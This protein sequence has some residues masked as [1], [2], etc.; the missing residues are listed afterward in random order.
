[1]GVMA[2][3]VSAQRAAAVNSGIVFH[4]AASANNGV[5]A[6]LTIPAPSGATAGDVLVASL[7]VE[8]SPAISVPVGWTLVRSDINPNAL[9]LVQADYVHVLGTNEPQSYTWNFSAANGASGGIVAYGGV[10]PVKPVDA[11]SGAVTPATATQFTAPSITTSQPGDVLLDVTG[12]GVNRTLMAPAAMTPEYTNATTASGQKTQILAADQV[13]AS[14]GAS[15]S[16]TVTADAAA[17]GIAQLIALRPAAAASPS[18]QVTITAPGNGATVSGTQVVVSASATAAAGIAHVQ[19]LLDNSPLGN[20]LTAPP[21]SVTW[22]T[23]TATNGQHTLTATVV[24]NN[25]TSAT[26]VPVTVN[27]SNTVGGQPTATV[28]LST[29][30][31]DTDATLT[32]SATG[33]SPTNHPVTFQYTWRVNGSVVKVTSFISSTTDSLDLSLPGNGDYGDSISVQVTPQD[34]V[35]QGS[36]V[37]ASATVTKPPT[38]TILEY[39]LPVAGNPGGITVGPDGNFWISVEQSQFIEVIRPSGAQSRLVTLPTA[40]NL[41]GI[42]AGPDGNIWAAEL[43]ANKIA[44][45]TV[46]GQ[47]TEYNSPTPQSGFGGIA[48]GSDG[49]LWFVEGK[50]SKVGRVTTAGVFGEF[51]TPTA[52][53]FP[54]SAARGPDGNIWFCELN[55]G[56]LGKITP[57]GTI[58]EYRLPSATSKPNVITAG[59]DGNMW[60]TEQTGKIGRITTTGVIT[61]FRLPNTAALPV[62]ITSGPDGNLWFAENKTGKIG[63]ITPGGGITEFPLHVATAQPDKIAAGPDGNLWFTEHNANNLGRITP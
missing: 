43:T 46:S 21:Y 30:K 18:P 52:N 51:P 28:S 48:S 57:T 47:I 61:E 36:T 35:V 9:H 16:R 53:A 58:T 8:N 60:F 62:G 49:N 27:V 31:P 2:V 12:I 4:G 5:A 15:G 13:L 17:V 55:V 39:P 11:S 6:V 32:A 34:G 44:K 7:A 40:G 23:T 10:D 22:D 63:R 14:A 37:Q 29:S 38:G 1:M 25:G 41:G 54:H 19:F 26:S 33:S 42:T 24:D 56:K 3:S 45:I 59:P 20:P 50:A